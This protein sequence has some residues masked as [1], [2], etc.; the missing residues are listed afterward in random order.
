MSL[1][2]RRTGKVPVLLAVRPAMR[3]ESA[4]VL[5]A[6]SFVAVRFGDD[7][8]LPVTGKPGDQDLAGSTAP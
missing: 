3:A 7:R 4:T 2:K 6:Q 1:A 8:E 5:V